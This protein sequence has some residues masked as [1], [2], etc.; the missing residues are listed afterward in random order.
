[1]TRIDITPIDEAAE[2]L[3]QAQTE[4]V[5]LREILR[6]ADDGLDLFKS[7]NRVLSMELDMLREENGKIRAANA[8]QAKRLAA[9]RQD[10]RESMARSG[11]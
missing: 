10:A 7:A 2:A 6:K 1:M 3:R 5:M 11:E 4:I 8:D 9:Y